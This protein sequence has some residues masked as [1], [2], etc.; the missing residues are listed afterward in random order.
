M[1]GQDGLLPAGRHGV[2][3]DAFRHHFVEAFAGSSTRARLFTR[4][5]RHR[6]A[7]T[8]WSRSRLSDRWQLRHRQ[9]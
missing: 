1:L 6:E 4:W 7:L 5:E 2:T 3:V 9:G 8:R